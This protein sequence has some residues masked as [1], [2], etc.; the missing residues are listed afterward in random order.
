MVENPMFSWAF[1]GTADP[2]N[3]SSLS[4]NTYIVFEKLIRENYTL[5]FWL[6][7]EINEILYHTKKTAWVWKL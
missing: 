4:R 2:G 7:T 1:D 5:K 6:R 3:A